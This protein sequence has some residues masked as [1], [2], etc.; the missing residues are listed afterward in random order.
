MVIFVN[1]VGKKQSSRPC[2]LT[3]AAQRGFVAQVFNA[4]GLR[5]DNNRVLTIYLSIFS[6]RNC[7]RFRLLSDSVV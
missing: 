4:T 7:S 6:W 3:V 5:V 2:R 1:K